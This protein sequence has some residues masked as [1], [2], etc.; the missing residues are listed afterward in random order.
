MAADNS[1]QKKA[2]L[3]FI[4]SFIK[5]HMSLHRGATNCDIKSIQMGIDLI[6]KPTITLGNGLVAMNIRQVQLCYLPSI[7]AEGLLLCQTLQKQAKMNSV[8]LPNI[9]NLITYTSYNNNNN[10]QR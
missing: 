7:I 5:R 9:L 2:I 8:N 3:K 4:F 1:E 10:T 6:L